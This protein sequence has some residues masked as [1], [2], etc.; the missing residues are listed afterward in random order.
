MKK[1]PILELYK[2]NKTVF[3]AQEVS[4]IWQENS[5][6]RFKNKIK[7]YLDKGDLIRLRQ[8]IYAK[9]NYNIQEAAA[10]IY[11]PSYISF[12]T[13]LAQAGII[14]QYYETIYVASYLSREILLKDGQKIIY[15][16]LKNEVLLNPKGLK[17]KNNI[18]IASKERA[19]LDLIY[20]NP[21]YYFDNLSSIDWKLCFDLIKIYQNKNLIKILKNYKNAYLGKT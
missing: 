8:G 7:Y 11:K 6:D 5:K 4:L 10:K 20:I 13:V 17:R 21:N 3:T 12:E 19:F 18:T 15:H 2:S 14:F 16:K 9:E 1:S